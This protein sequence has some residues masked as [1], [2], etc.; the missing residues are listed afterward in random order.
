MAQKFLVLKLPI[1]RDV[2]GHGHVDDHGDGN[3]DGFG[4]TKYYT[5]IVVL[6]GQ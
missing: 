5:R 6:H 4:H 2:G 3:H 1:D